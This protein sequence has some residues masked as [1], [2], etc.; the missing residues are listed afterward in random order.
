M[1]FVFRTKYAE[2]I[3]CRPAVRSAVGALVFLPAVFCRL[4]IIAGSS[5]G[6]TR[7]RRGLARQLRNVSRQCCEDVMRSCPAAWR[8]T[9]VLITV[10][11]R[12]SAPQ[13]KACCCCASERARLQLHQAPGGEADHME[14]NIRVGGVLD[15][16]AQVHH[17]VGHRRVPGCVC[18]HNPA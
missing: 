4:C 2:T 8:N 15:E 3:I 11:G 9:P 5:N 17:G 1:V 18:V 16:G 14:Q 6:F 12:G 10:G 13:E 7:G